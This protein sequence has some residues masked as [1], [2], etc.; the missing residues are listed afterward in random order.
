MANHR[1][2]HDAERSLRERDPIRSAIRSATLL[3][4]K[5]AALFRFTV[6]HS[7]FFAAIVGVMTLIQAYV[8]TGMIPH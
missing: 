3:V 1:N 8:L 5:E 7:L 2:S 4:G 6:R